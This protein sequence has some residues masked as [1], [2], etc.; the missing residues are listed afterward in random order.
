M[1]STPPKSDARRVYM[2]EAAGGMVIKDDLLEVR[3]LRDLLDRVIDKGIVLDPA[4]R[5]GMAVHNHLGEDHIVIGTF[6][7]RLE[8]RAA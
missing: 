4:A 3:D 8:K 1:C 6:D 5:I 7:T 2:L